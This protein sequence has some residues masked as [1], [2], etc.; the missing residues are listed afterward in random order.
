MKKLLIV[1]CA[2]ILLAG[3]GKKTNEPVETSKPEEVAK[4]DVKSVVRCSLQSDST[5]VTFSFN[6]NDT[7]S[8]VED[9]QMIMDLIFDTITDE[10]WN[11]VKTQDFCKMTIEDL[12][13]DV[14]IY[15]NCKQVE[16]GKSIELTFDIDLSKLEEFENGLFKATMTKDQVFKYLEDQKAICEK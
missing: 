7:K 6:Y 10:Q 2:L 15:S 3:C 9:G 11:S 14:E 5:R 8:I 12:N 4:P 1:L 16:D 13:K